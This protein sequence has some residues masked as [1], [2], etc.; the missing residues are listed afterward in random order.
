MDCPLVGTASRLERRGGSSLCF[1]DLDPAGKGET[2]EDTCSVM[3][4]QGRWSPTTGYRDG[5]FGNT[6]LGRTCRS[7]VI[8]ANP[9]E[10]PFGCSRNAAWRF[11]R[12]PS[13]AWLSIQAF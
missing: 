4:W 3:A 10:C 6:D 13:V 7:P 11:I 5:F 2:I 9:Q 12:L 8:Q 1:Y